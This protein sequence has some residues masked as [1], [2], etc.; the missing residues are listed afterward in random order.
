M[1]GRGVCLDAGCTVMAKLEASKVRLKLNQRGAPSRRIAR[2]V[3]G[4]D[5]LSRKGE[6]VSRV[7]GAWGG[8][9]GTV[10]PGCGAA[11]GLQ[12]KAQG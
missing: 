8:G 11:R 7:K 10:T 3:G 9:A 2:E 6:E 12:V 5:L 4:I 1:P